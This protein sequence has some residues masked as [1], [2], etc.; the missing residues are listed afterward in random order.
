VKAA[1]GRAGLFQTT[2][3]TGD[4]ADS[5]PGHVAAGHRTISHG[6]AVLATG[7][8]EAEPDQYGYGTHARIV[9][10]KTLE[11]QI[12]SGGIDA[13]ALAAVV[14]IQCV[15][16]REEPR[17][18]C[19]RVCCPTSLKHALYLKNAHADIAVYIL[20]RGIMATGFTETYYTR[21]RRAG[22]IFMQ[23]A[24]SAKP[25]IT[26]QGG[27]LMVRTHDPIVNAPVEIQTDLVVL[28]AGIRPA[29]TPELQELFGTSCDMDGFVQEAEPKWRPVDSAREGIFA[30]GL[31]LA[32]QT[33]DSAIASG[34]AAAQRA[35]RILGRPHLPAGTFTA[36]VR[37]SLC[38]LCRRCI[39]TCPFAA[40]W[41]DGRQGRIEINSGMC[42]G[43]GACAAA[44]PSGAAVLQGSPKQ[45]VLEM[46]DAAL[47]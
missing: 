46:I 17:N 33:L 28:A 13:C 35:L 3:E 41:I 2:L 45:Q 32:P 40:R 15:G 12:A 36:T 31:A 21:A 23:Y 38:A 19:S 39:D 18:Y 42:Q 16:S 25:Q 7:G 34:Q 37:H 24:P 6:V 43:C 20:H 29:P 8:Q 9:T 14:M 4:G 26:T 47:V 1:H 22:V 11:Q 5:P 27:L 30:C 44:C 10:Q